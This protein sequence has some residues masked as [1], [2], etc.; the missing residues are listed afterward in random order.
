MANDRQMTL[1]PE[2][3]ARVHR[4]IEDTGPEQGV[5]YH[6]DE[7]YDACVGPSLPSVIR[8]VRYGSSPTAP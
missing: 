6:T 4:A 8:P 5:S 2:L 7:D 3:V 1:T